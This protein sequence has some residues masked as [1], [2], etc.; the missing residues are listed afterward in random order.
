MVSIGGKSPQGTYS[1]ARDAKRDHMS[2]QTF[3][4]P[5]GK[6]R[7]P[8]LPRGTSW[9]KA[10][11]VWWETWR[12]S[13]QAQLMV[14]TDWSAMLEAARIHAM[15]WGEYSEDLKPSEYSSLSKE[16]HRITGNYGLT[17]A[18]RLKLRMRIVG[19]TPEENE[20]REPRE[21]LPNNVVDMYRQ[22]LGA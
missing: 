9:P 18:D 19:D 17:L 14:D 8:R 2:P 10:T 13:P 5:D 16:L 12:R 22:K 11:E 20:G 4:V 21:G 15:L 3:L 1:R 7:G 6:L